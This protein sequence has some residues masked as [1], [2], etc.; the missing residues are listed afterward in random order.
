MSFRNLV[1]AV[2]CMALLGELGCAPGMTLRQGLYGQQAETAVS[3]LVRLDVINY[4]ASD[5]TIYVVHAGVPFRIGRVDGGDRVTFYLR[6]VEIGV[7]GRVQLSA[8]EATSR[9]TYT[10]DLVP[11]S[12]GRR[13]ELRLERNL[14]TT[15]FN[16]W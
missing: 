16:V 8:R 7:P 12:T 14:A 11:V 6:P 10:S 15:R 3:G 9:R 5:M 1:I 13:L 2:A 4:N